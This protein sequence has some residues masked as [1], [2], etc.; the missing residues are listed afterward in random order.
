MLLPSTPSMTSLLVVPYQSVRWV[1]DG[2][3]PPFY[4]MIIEG[5]QG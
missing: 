5:K 2:I 3:L 1:S 4:S